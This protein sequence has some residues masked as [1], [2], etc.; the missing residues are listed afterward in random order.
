MLERSMHSGFHKREMIEVCCLVGSG[1]ASG[2][3]GFHEV[4]TP[5][6]PEKRKETSS[7]VNRAGATMVPVK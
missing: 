5:M 7:A 3:T 6:E 4:R 2:L 1:A